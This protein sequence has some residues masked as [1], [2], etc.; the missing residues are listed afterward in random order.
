MPHPIRSATHFDQ[1]ISAIET[2]QDL[3]AGLPERV[4]SPTGGEAVPSSLDHLWNF[5][6]TQSIL[7]TQLQPTI[8]DPR[9]LI[10]T[11]Y[12]SMAGKILGKLQKQEDDS[13]E[14]EDIQEARDIS[15][16]LHQEKTLNQLLQKLRHSNLAG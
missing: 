2:S 15:D 10:P 13:T 9:I 5:T 8:Y 1:G 16:I 6:T 4:G 3:P 14:P 7:I 11:R 12:Y